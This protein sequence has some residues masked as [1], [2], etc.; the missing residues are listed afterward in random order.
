MACGEEVACE[1]AAWL[2]VTSLQSNAAEALCRCNVCTKH[3]PAVACRGRGRNEGRF[4]SRRRHMAALTKLWKG[5]GRHWAASVL[6][7]LILLLLQ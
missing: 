3:G 7:Q 5:A 2:R 6:L 4:P 1:K